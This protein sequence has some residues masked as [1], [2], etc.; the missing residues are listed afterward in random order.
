MMAIPLHVIEWAGSGLGLA[1]AALLSLNLRASRFGWLL[2]LLSN[3]A[4]IVY[5]IR[6]GAHGLVAMQIGFTLTSLVGV[7]R[8]FVAAKQ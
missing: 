1:G 2:F 3:S 7:Y 6:V 5:G 8:W 4:W